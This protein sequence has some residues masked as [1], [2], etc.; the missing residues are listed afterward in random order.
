MLLLCLCINHMPIN[1]MLISYL[2]PL[3]PCC[4]TKQVLSITVSSGQ[5]QTVVTTALG[6]VEVS[7]FVDKKTTQLDLRTTAH[8]RSSLLGV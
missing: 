6:A 2:Y 8:T 3:L 5:N 4:S 1:M 7:V